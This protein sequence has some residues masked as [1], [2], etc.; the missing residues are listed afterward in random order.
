[1]FS[2]KRWQHVWFEPEPQS[3]SR[4]Q[5]NPWMPNP[6]TTLPPSDTWPGAQHISVAP[7]TIRSGGQ[8]TCGDAAVSAPISA[9]SWRAQR[10]GFAQHVRRGFVTGPVGHEDAFFGQQRLCD[11]SPQYDVRLSQHFLPHSSCPEAHRLQTPRSGSLQ[12]QFR[13][14]QAGP[15]R[16]RPPG[17]LGM[18]VSVVLP[19]RRRRTH[20]VVFGQQTPSGW[21]CGWQFCSSGRQGEKQTPLTQTCESPQQIFDLGLPQN[22]RPSGQTYCS[23]QSP[24]RVHVMYQGQHDTP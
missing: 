24:A 18:Q 22:G 4:L 5:Q 6:A 17:H 21:P 19:P 20:S 9:G 3:W 11:G 13:G 10:F 12:C 2:L 14:Q 15:H 8:Q 1:M 7:G 23:P 16:L